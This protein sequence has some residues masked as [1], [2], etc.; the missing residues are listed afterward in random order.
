[1]GKDNL[2]VTESHALTSE[3]FQKE[4]VMEN[5]QCQGQNLY[6]MVV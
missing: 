3:E 1:M 2:P 6:K 5:G 4:F